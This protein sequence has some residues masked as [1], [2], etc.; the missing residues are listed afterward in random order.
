[1]LAR[2]RGIMAAVPV[3]LHDEPR[4]SV[5]RRQGVPE[6]VRDASRHFPQD[7]QVLLQ[8]DLLAEGLDLGEIGEQAEHSFDRSGGAHR[9]VGRADRRHHRP[10]VR[11]LASRIG[12]GHDLARQ[13][14][15]GAE[16]S[17]D[18][19]DQPFGPP[20][21]VAIL[22][23]DR[24]GPI[25]GQE[26]LGRRVQDRQPAG[27]VEDE[28]GAGHPAD[29]VIARERRWR[30]GPLR[31]LQAGQ[32]LLL[33]P[34]LVED[35]LER[36]DEIV[37]LVPGH[38]GHETRHLAGRLDGG[39]HQPPVRLQQPAGEQD[40]ERQ[41]EHQA[42]RLEGGHER[43]VEIDAPERRDLGEDTDDRDRR[44]ALVLDRTVGRER[45]VARARQAIERRHH[46]CARLESPRRSG[47]LREQGVRFP[48]PLRVGG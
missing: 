23:T 6:L 14:F 15:P 30:R 8:P 29:Q 28:D 21:K 16:T 13:A 36:L 38:V 24:G 5:D 22:A 10:Q 46:A 43:Q 9:T 31:P 41:D 39:A 17:I 2:Y 32:L 12:E 11:D 44:A 42:G 47:A 20:E 26:P 40:D 18:E 35:P 25:E 1:M 37:G 19:I 27:P 7:R 33:R 34:Q 48:D 4:Q 45:G 3:S